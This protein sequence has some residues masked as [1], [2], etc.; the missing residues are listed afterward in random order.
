MDDN[1]LQKIVDSV[2]QYLEQDT[3]GKLVDSSRHQTKTFN[4]FF[5]MLKY[6][7]EFDLISEE[8]YF[9]ELEQLR[10]TYFAEGTD[11]WV[12][13]TQQIYDYQ[14][15]LINDEKKEFE[16]M[17]DDIADYAIE[18]LEEV[19][20][21]Q[22]KLAD[23]LFDLGPLY[24][25]N[26]VIIGGTTDYYYSLHNIEN[27]IELIKKYGENMQKLEQ[28]G[29]NL[30][31]PDEASKLLFDQIKAMDS[32]DGLQF[33]GALLNASDSVYADYVM[34]V[35][36]KNSLAQNVSKDAFSEEFNTAI[37]SSYKYMYD[38]LSKAGYEVPD[39][40]YVTGSISAE[41]FGEGF[42]EELDNQLEIIRGMITEFNTEF[43]TQIPVGGNIYN[44]T[45]TSYNITAGDDGNTVEQI[46]R[47]EIVKRLSGVT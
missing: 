29:L 23:N 14:K 47:H 25:V 32:A 27:E 16:S 9:A 26:K 28:R 41:K 11:N 12:K 42:V 39:G 21:K 17:Y 35:W 34:S 24:N 18:K 45:N 33:M 40:F 44:T 3:L 4:G 31:V 37:D 2:V 38:T 1:T 13:Y 5:E 22:Q 30:S 43:D 19:Q 6:R 15:K 36:E 10:D 46:K 7:R 8:E 20:N